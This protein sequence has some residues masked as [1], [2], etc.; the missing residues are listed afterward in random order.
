MDPELQRVSAKIMYQETCFIIF[1]QHTEII[2]RAF[3]EM[4]VAAKEGSVAITFDA[5]NFRCNFTQND[6]C[7]LG[8]TRYY[9]ESLGYSF[10]TSYSP[11]GNTIVTIG[12]N[13]APK[14]L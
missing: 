10:K 14:S 8:H 2:N 1:A 11:N 13:Q 12:W 3:H 4:R 5:R 6:V 9:F 7:E